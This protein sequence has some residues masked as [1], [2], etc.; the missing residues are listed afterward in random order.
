MRDKVVQ[1]RLTLSHF[2]REYYLHRH[3]WISSAISNS[4]MR[5]STVPSIC[6]PETPSSC[7]DFVTR[8]NI[9]T[10]TQ[11]HRLRTPFDSFFRAVRI[12]NLPPHIIPTSLDKLS[13]QI[14][15]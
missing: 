5:C 7:L 1:K 3:L 9:D 14:Q 11:D 4:P 12:Y 10:D 2:Q 8:C 6:S 13:S 15:L